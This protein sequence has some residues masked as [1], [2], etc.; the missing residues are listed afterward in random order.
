MFGRSARSTQV[1]A[2]CT[3]VLLAGLAACES[4][5]ITAPPQAAGTLPPA[6]GSGG[7]APATTKIDRSALADVG[8]D[9]PLDYADPRMWLCRPGNDPDECDANMDSTELLP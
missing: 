3:F 9:K 2:S 8:S 5:T 4:D 1:H 6:A 7:P